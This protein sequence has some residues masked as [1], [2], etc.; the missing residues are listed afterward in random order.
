M[1]AT[2]S[3]RTS[4]RLQ[5]LHQLVQWVQQG[6][7]NLPRQMRVQ[8]CTASTAMAEILLNDPEVH[9][10]FQQVCGIGVPQCVNVSG[11]SNASCFQSLSECALQC[12]GRQRAPVAK[13]GGW[14]HALGGAM[15]PPQLTQQLQRAHR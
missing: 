1:S 13:P 15:S 8:L 3:K 12:G 7:A 5:V 6:V 14:E 10:S 2:S 11:L 9:A 4:K